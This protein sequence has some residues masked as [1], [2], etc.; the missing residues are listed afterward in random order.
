MC[1]EG[2]LRPHPRNAAVAERNERV[3]DLTMKK[4]TSRKASP[5]K[6]AP[7]KRSAKLC[8]A[9]LHPMTAANRY[10]HPSK[11]TMCRA[12][13]RDYMRDYMREHIPDFDLVAVPKG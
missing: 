3:L 4:P 13:I 10:V 1:A 7:A 6:A 5:A 8:K 2:G 11:G 12:C 9:G